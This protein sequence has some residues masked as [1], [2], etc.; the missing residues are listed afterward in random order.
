MYLF[1]KFKENDNVK[2]CEI[3]VV[4]LMCNVVVKFIGSGIF[5]ICY[6]GK[7]WGIDVVIK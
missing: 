5:G 4:N 6:L 1:V 2:L 3:S 7:Y